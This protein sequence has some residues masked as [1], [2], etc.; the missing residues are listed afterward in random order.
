MPVLVLMRVGVCVYGGRR[1]VQHQRVP[2]RLAQVPPLCQQRDALQ[3]GIMPAVDRC[4]V[5]RTIV[6]WREG[7]DARGGYT[8][9]DLVH[10]PAA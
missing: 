8:A 2:Q 7:T 9:G 5:F 3:R 6:A 1:H 4:V 10:L